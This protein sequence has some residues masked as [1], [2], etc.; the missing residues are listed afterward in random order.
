MSYRN[1]PPSSG[2]YAPLTYIRGFPVDVTTLLVAVH[3]VLMVIAALAITAKP[4][5]ESFANLVDW[6]GFNSKELLQ[7]K[8]W[9][10]VTYPFLHHI[11]YE[12]IWFAIDMVLF[13]WFGRE[14]ERYIGRNA[15]IW[16]YALIVIVSVVAAGLAS[17]ALSA[18]RPI[19]GSN[20]VHFAVFIGFVTIYPNVQF[21]FGLVAKWLAFGFLAIYILR[22]L[23]MHDWVSL[24]HLMACC[25]S[26]Y[27]LLKSVGVRGGF[28]WFESIG[29][30]RDQQQEK[31]AAERRRAYEVE[32][33]NRDEN[34]DAVL[35]K[36]S[37]EGIQSLKP[38]ERRLL[39]KASNDLH[40]RDTD[41]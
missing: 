25:G 12:H 38:E 18:P 30:W 21:I 9:T 7:G 3:I 19:W 20:Y 36:I 4:G 33:K 41:R 23:V 39:E 29:S 22:D 26:S 13:F 28:S 5:P 24:I 35:E 27:F 6:F 37:K 8:I 11:A 32:L 31:K 34:V 15:Y 40:Q 16:F 10:L 14:V 2:S 17:L 1:W